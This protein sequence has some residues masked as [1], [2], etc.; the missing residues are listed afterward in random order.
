MPERIVLF[1]GT[2]NPIHHGHLIAARA[3]AEYFHFPRITFVPAAVP[4]HKHFEGASDDGSAGADRSPVLPSAEERH[5]MVRLA[6]RGEPLFDVSDVEL[7]RRP[8]SYTFDTLM[9][10]R[11]EHGLEAQLHW[12]VGADML[13]DLPTWRRADEVVDMATIIT[14]ARPPWSERLDR[15]LVKLRERFTADQAARLAA[16]IAPTP[17][18]DISSTQLRHRVRDGKSV[19]FLTPDSVIAYIVQKGL[20]RQGGP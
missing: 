13:A 11:T 6:I 20:Y 5:E 4:P 9:A 18:V 16:A 12:V 8:P 15:T 14:A 7:N 1:G 19:K 2:F 3:V 17:L 10:M